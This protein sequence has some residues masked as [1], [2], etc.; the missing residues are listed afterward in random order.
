MLKDGM[1]KLVSIVLPVKINEDGVAFYFKIRKSK[2]VC[3][4][5]LEFPGGKIEANESPREA[6]IRE[7][8]EE[9]SIQLNTDWIKDFGLH[10]FSYPNFNVWLYSFYFDISLLKENERAEFEEVFIRFDEK[11]YEVNTF[12]AN[13]QIIKE[14]IN[15][16]S[17]MDSHE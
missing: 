3:D 9:C 14:F 16:I 11:D 6:G 1:V 7:F 4:G 17:I 10:K 13:F 2:D 12:A 8:S 5:L 15:S